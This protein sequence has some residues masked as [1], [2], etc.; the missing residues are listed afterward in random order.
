M[1]ETKIELPKSITT[2]ERVNPNTMILFG[3][4]KVGKSSIVATLP[5]HLMIDY[6]NGSGFI[7]AV[8]I[9]PPEDLGHVGKFNWLKDLAKEIKAQGKPYSYIIVDTI[10]E[11][12]NSAEWVG[13]WNYMNSVQG[14]GFNRTE[15]GGEMLKPT[16]P[17]YLSVHTLADGYGYR[18]SRA[19]LMD[20]FDT[21]SG[22]GSI[23][24]IFIAHMGEKY[25]S[26]TVGTE[27]VTKFIDL[28]GKAKD[29]I[30]RK[31]DCIGYVYN[32]EGKVMVSFKG[33]EDRQGGNRAKHLVGFEGPLD[34]SSIFIKEK[35]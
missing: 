20:I 16:D 32:E 31:V 29:I 22:L 35:E 10:S 28:T 8:K 18:W 3:A 15:K 1:V 11:L 2:A 24:T 25:Y 13:T 12:D 4:P 14:K 9:S 34:W 23:C 7:D 30:A 5:N 26:K 6:E 17:N 21:L 27:V 33:N 19:A